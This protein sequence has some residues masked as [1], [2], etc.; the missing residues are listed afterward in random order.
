ML[1]KEFKNNINK[2]ILQSNSYEELCDEYSIFC[3]HFKLGQPND[4]VF[5]VVLD[6]LESFINKYGV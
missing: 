1:L 6:K 2:I 5:R 4:D 3:K